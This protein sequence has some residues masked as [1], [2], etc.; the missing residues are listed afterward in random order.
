MDDELDQI[1]LDMQTG[2]DGAFARFSV[3]FGPLLLRKY[4]SLGLSLADAESLAISSVTDIALKVDRF[5]PL[6]SGSFRQ[7]ALAVARNAFREQLRKR[8]PELLGDAQDEVS[9]PLD[10]DEPP[11]VAEAIDAMQRAVQ[12]LAEPD[13]S[14]VLARQAEPYLTF[15]EIGLRLGLTEGTARTRYHRALARLRL[16]LTNDPA[17]MA[18]RAHHSI[19]PLAG[20]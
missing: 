9:A 10:V 13:R 11:A 12:G 5:K 16:L 7:W 1:A 15:A 4:V 20:G 2:L 3:L 19:P 6:G 14:I 8:R 17:V 18:W